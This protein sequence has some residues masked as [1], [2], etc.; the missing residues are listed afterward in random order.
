MRFFWSLVCVF[1][2]HRWSL[3][4]PEMGY[5]KHQCWRCNRTKHTKISSS[6]YEMK[7][8]TEG[9]YFESVGE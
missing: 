7:K 4:G 2:G 3:R 6:W 5:V 9:T 8:R 1:F